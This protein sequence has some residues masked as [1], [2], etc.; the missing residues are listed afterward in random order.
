MEEGTKT[1]RGCSLKIYYPFKTRGTRRW[2][3]DSG[4]EKTDKKRK[5]RKSEG[6]RV[7][8]LQEKKEKNVILSIEMPRRSHGRRPVKLSPNVNEI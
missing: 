8:V 1:Q 6:G 2:G 5:G 3:R 7:R 4:A